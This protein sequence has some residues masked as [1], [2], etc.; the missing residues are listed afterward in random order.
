ML[1]RNSEIQRKESYFFDI[2]IFIKI[3]YF[4]YFFY[5][6]IIKYLKIKILIL[7]LYKKF[8]CIHVECEGFFA[9][10]NFILF[11]LLV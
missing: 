4:I 9:Q 5:L 10:S 6:F 11:Y 1:R 3:L 8:F 2:Y 7:N